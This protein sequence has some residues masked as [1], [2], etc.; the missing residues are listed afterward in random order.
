MQ[1]YFCGGL[2]NLEHKVPEVN[3]I[4][5]LCKLVGIQYF[6]LR[7]SVLSDLCYLQTSLFLSAKTSQTNQGESS[8]YVALIGKKKH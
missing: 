1:C 3:L 2:E 7:F 6:N 4:P 5:N 8:V